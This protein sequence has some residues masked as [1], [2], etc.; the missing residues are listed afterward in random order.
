MSAQQGCSIRNI[1]PGDKIRITAKWSRYEPYNIG[2]VMYVDA[3]GKDGVY[4]YGLVSDEA[5]FI[6]QNEYEV[7]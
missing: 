2:D 6:H 5:T 1:R 4:V 7:I 3:L